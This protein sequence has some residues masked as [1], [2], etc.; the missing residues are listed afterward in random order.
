M[1]EYEAGFFAYY[2][3]VNYAMNPY[4]CGIDADRWQ[5]GWLDAYDIHQGALESCHAAYQVSTN[6]ETTEGV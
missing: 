4:Y 5:C 6:P 2:S 3:G 1:D